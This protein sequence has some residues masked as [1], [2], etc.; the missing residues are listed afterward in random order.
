MVVWLCTLVGQSVMFFVCPPSTQPEL[1]LFR[2]NTKKHSYCSCHVLH[3]IYLYYTLQGSFLNNEIIQ[4]R[5]N[6]MF[7]LH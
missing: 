3:Y 7:A 2:R 4:G 6:L 1:E 5:A